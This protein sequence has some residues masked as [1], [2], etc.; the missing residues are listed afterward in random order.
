MSRPPPAAP[1]PARPAPPASRTRRL[2]QEVGP[3][4]RG[5]EDVD[6]AGAGRPWPHRWRG[7]APTRCRRGHGSAGPVDPTGSR[8]T[9]ST[10]R[11]SAARA[12]AVVQR[13]EAVGPRRD[14]GGGLAEPLRPARGL[15]GRQPSGGAGGQGDEHVL[16]P[17][18]R[19]LRRQP[20]GDGSLQIRPLSAGLTGP[21]GPASAA[22]ASRA[23][24][25]AGPKP[26]ASGPVL[27]RRTALEERRLDGG[28]RPDPERPAASAFGL[29]GG[30]VGGGRPAAA[31]GRAD[32]G[33]GHAGQV[34]QPVGVHPPIQG[35]PA[36]PQVVAQ[37]QLVDG[38]E[39]AA[40]GPP[41]MVQRRP[42]P[43]SSQPRLHSS[44]CECRWGSPEPLDRWS[45]QAATAPTVGDQPP[46]RPLASR[47]GA[48]APGRR[49]PRATAAR[50]AA[51]IS[52]PPAVASAASNDTDLGA[53][54]VR[55]HPA[56]R[57]AGF[58]AG[59]KLPS[60]GWQPCR[61]RTRSR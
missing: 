12:G 14:G 18:R 2:R 23:S 55:S 41:G 11:R 60:S 61:T 27:P 45:K 25:S 26:A 50:W 19:A 44:R 47:S 5:V 1:P 20:Q 38:A 52:S 4:G 56:R 24:A 9:S 10:S 28:A 36:G 16:V 31:A 6:R 37:A 59:R 3:S 29:E 17:E 39:G 46:A 54:S 32:R 51:M 22:A 40:S 43:R 48:A 49:P 21:G 53:A 7:R 42:H 33:P 13:G 30:P 58:H 8:S 34:R 57:R 35:Q 15:A